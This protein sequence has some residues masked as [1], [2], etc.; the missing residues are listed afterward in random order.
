MDCFFMEVPFN[1]WPMLLAIPRLAP[2]SAK[3]SEE[4]AAE[5]GRRRAKVGRGRADRG[6]WARIGTGRLSRSYG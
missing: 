3:T 5:P 2:L 1:N 6:A 4:S